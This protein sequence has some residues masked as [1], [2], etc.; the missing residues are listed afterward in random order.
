MS[1]QL[2]LKIRKFHHEK[3]EL[4]SLTMRKTE[5][6]RFYVRKFIIV[7]FGSEGWKYLEGF[8]GNKRGSVCMQLKGNFGM[9][10][11]SGPTGPF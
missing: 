11:L 4:R 9:Y 8:V 1:R 3:N 10:K 7:D 2:P 5:A 6:R